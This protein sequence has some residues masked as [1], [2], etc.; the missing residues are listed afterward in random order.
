MER[1]L[2]HPEQISAAYICLLQGTN[3]ECFVLHEQEGDNSVE[4]AF[5]QLKD[6]MI[7]P[8][9]LALPNFNQDFVVKIDTCGNGIGA[10]LMQNSKPLAYFS[11]GWPLN[12]L[13]WSDISMD[14][15]ETLPSS[16]GKQVV[17]VIVDRLSKFSH[18]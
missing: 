16:P 4:S 10:M 18:S 7:T 3:V 14:F 1:V 5:Q 12:I 13:V 11:K 9:V 8:H 2:R 6:V 15:I 17:L